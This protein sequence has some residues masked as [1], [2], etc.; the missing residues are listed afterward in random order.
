[1][2]KEYSHSSQYGLKEL[3]LYIKEEESKY[4]KVIITDK[5]DQPYILLL[6]Y[7]K[8]PP[9]QFQEN[10]ILSGRDKYGFSTVNSFDKYH[11]RPIDYDQEAPN[12]P[13]SLIV[14]TG[15]E[16]PEHANIVKTIYFPNGEPAFEIVAN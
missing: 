1:M 2:A 15:E 14:G 7:L 12:S 13:R 8:Y 4:E 16:I 11:F 9:E 6:Y 10:H 5:Y 3:A